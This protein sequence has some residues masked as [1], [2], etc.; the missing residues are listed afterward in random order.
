MANAGNDPRAQ[1]QIASTPSYS[2]TRLANATAYGVGDAVSD[3]AT[4]P[5]I[6]SWTG[7]RVAMYGGRVVSATLHKSTNSLTNAAFTLY[8]FDATVVP[9][10]FDDNSGIA[11]TDDEMKTCIGSIPFAASDGENML[12]GALYHANDLNIAYVTDSNN[13]IYGVMV[14][15]GAYTPGSGEIITWTLGL[16][17][18]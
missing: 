4:T 18:D 12:T 11:I 6:M 10:G 17:K 15:R 14:A 16:M 9:A 2:F 3:H 13:L 7:A 5:T 1:I 8:L